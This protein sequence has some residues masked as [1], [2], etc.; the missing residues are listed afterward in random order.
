MEP[1][2]ARGIKPAPTMIPVVMDQNRY[3]RS[4]GSFTTVRKRTMDS[5]PTIPSDVIR[6][7]D[8]AKITRVVIKSMAIRVIPKDEEYMTPM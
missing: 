1:I 5:A 6:F 4:S 7:E 2:T 3:T 8:T